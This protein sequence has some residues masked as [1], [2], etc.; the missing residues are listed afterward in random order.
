MLM[1]VVV[2]PFC[3]AEKTA[4]PVEFED[5]A[6]V[7]AEVVGLPTP[8]CSWTVIAPRLAVE[9]AL[10]ETALEV[11]TSFVATLAIVSCWVAV[12]SPDFAAVI[13]GVPPF[14]SP[15]QKLT[16]DDPDEMLTLVIALPFCD[17]ENR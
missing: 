2:A 9:D 3:V 13:V 15:Y 16:D 1:L 14:V 4:V 10:P 5:S 8:S 12:V 17:S 11:M 6:T 7:C